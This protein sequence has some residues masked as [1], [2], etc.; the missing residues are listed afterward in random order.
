MLR[1][2]KSK[3]K[4]KSNV[5]SRRKGKAAFYKA[6]LAKQICGFLLFSHDLSDV[7]R[8]DNLTVVFGI[9]VE[10]VE[11]VISIRDDIVQHGWIPRCTT[12]ESNV[13]ESACLRLSAGLDLEIG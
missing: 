11:P 6:I 4:G 7:E 3:R 10:L 5:I 8:T 12:G 1:G 9:N 13:R 2:K